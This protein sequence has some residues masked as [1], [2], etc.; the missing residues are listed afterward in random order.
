VTFVETDLTNEMQLLL[1]GLLRFHSVNATLTNL[2]R[3][4]SDSMPVDFNTELTKGK[5]SYHPLQRLTLFIGQ[6]MMLKL[7]VKCLVKLSGSFKSLVT[8]DVRVFDVLIEIYKLFK[9]HP[10][11]TLK[12]DQPNI[13][14]FDVIYRNI[15]TLA[16]HVI[17]LGPHKAK[18][19]TDFFSRENNKSI[20]LEY[21]K[22]Y[23]AK[24]Y[25]NI[26]HSHPHNM[27]NMS[28]VSYS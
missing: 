4:L 10:P 6:K 22:S 27:T 1:D 26:T 3:I 11:E 23:V 28:N 12:E 16:D 2:L 14:D 8:E 9:L 17:D 13:K 5:K 15:R 21:I 7:T 20:F 19:F 25:P 24:Y 18:E